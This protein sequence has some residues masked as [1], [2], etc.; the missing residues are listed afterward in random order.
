MREYQYRV[1]K[2]QAVRFDGNPHSREMQELLGASSVLFSYVDS[3]PRV[4]VLCTP[5]GPQAVH[6]GHYV[7]RLPNGEFRAYDPYAFAEEFE[8]APNEVGRL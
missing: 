5:R 2:V 7:V 8:E 3:D 4:A 6:N 1:V